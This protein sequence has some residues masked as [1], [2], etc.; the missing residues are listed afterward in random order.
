M[1]WNGTATGKLSSREVLITA[2]YAG[3][4]IPEWPLD[5]VRPHFLFVW[6]CNQENAREKKINCLYSTASSLYLFDLKKGSLVKWFNHCDSL[7]TPWKAQHRI[8]RSN[9]ATSKYIPPKIESKGQTDTGLPMS[10]AAWLTLAEGQKQPR[11][12]QQIN[13]ENKM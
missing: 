3:R 6:N 4:K 11:C 1:F 9:D 2:L 13:G 5:L 10:M 12:R 7:A 8:I